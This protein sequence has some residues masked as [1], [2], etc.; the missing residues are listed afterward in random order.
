MLPP[1]HRNQIPEPHVRQLMGHHRGDAHALRHSRRG[2]VTE[3]IDLAVDDEPPILHG[4]C[5]EVGRGQHV[6]LRERICD[7]EIL[8]V[9]VQHPDGHVQRKAPALGLAGH[10]EHP[11]QDAI[12]GDALDG[13]KSAHGQSQQVGRHHRRLQEGSSALVAHK[14]FRGGRH[15]GDGRQP[16]RNGHRQHEGRLRARLVPTGQ[17]TPRIDRLQLCDGHRFLP[18]S[19]TVVGATIQAGHVRTQPSNIAQRQ[20]T[21]ACGQRLAEGKRHR[22]PVGIEC[23]LDGLQALGRGYN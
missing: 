19:W 9:E 18:T 11:H 4:P 5:R 13:I 7:L 6:Q 22:F 8:R 15:V 12:L 16:F 2:L 20:D 21:W 1:L 17:H 3:Q 10:G 23:D 14:G